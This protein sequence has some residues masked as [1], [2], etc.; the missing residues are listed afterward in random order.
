[1]QATEKINLQKAIEFKGFISEKEKINLLK[2]SKIVLIPSVR[3][4][5]GLIAI[6]ASALG[7]VPI[8]YN[9]HGLRDSIKNS[10]TGLLVPTNPQV[11]A[12]TSLKLLKNEALRVK[13]SRTGYNWSKKF[14]WQN[15]YQDF[16]IIS[17]ISKS[18]FR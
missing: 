18:L 4:G 6:E 2:K 3:E 10:Q 16:K 8:A 1:M 11:L 14:T 9:V 17:H 13:L 15:C 7:C 12:K 5:W